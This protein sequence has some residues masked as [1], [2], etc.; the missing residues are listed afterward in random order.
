MAMEELQIYQVFWIAV[1]EEFF[2]PTEHLI[3]GSHGGQGEVA[4][5]L[6]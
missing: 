4:A 2:D 1:S 3:T 6:T 5:F